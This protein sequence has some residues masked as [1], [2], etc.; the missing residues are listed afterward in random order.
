MLVPYPLTIEDY[1]RFI[2]LIQDFRPCTLSEAEYRKVFEEISRSSEI[3]TLQDPHTH[4]LVATATIQFE[5]K[6]IYN[7][8]LLAHVEDVCVKKEHRGR[9]VGKELMR[10]VVFRCKDLGAYKVTLDCAAETVPFYASA[11]FERRGQQM[12]CLL[13]DPL[14]GIPPVAE[15]HS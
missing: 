2:P 12:T 1:S 10:A 14:A 6:F 15:P 4:E 9:G 3:W 7:G 5:R 13:K 8:A 11:G